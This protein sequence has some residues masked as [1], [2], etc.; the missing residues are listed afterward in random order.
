MR[1]TLATLGC[2]AALGVICGQSAG[3]V[4]IDGG[5]IQQGAVAAA[6]VQ[7]AQYYERHTRHRIV[8]CYRELVF[9]PY[10]VCHTYYRW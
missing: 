10:V 1:K 4:A 6:P 5:A 8:K 3:A 2:A 7:Q 9:G